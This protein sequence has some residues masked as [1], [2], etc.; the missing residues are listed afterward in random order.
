MTSKLAGKL[1]NDFIKIQFS[2]D[3][4]VSMPSGKKTQDKVHSN[5]KK[6][7][8]IIVYDVYNK[9]FEKILGD[10]ST[11]SIFQNHIGFLVIE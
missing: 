6:T 10:N 1:A 7:L 2:Y 4:L 8:E 11:K 9:G 5:H 3:L